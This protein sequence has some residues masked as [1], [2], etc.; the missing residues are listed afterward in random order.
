[1]KKLP[2]QLMFIIG[3]VLISQ[4]TALSAEKGIETKQKIFRIR[5][6]E[7]GPFWAFPEIINATKNRLSFQR[8]Q[9]L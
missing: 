5:Y 7:G 4:I 2:K 8:E 9:T 1:M 6:I 3:I